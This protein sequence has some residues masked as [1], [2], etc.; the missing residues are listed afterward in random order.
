[1][2][3]IKRCKKRLRH[4]PMDAAE[5]LALLKEN[6]QAVDKMLIAFSGG[7]DSTFLLAVA[8]EVL[9]DEVTAVTVRSA[10][11]PQREYQS[12]VDF[13]RQLGIRHLFL[14]IEELAIPGFAENPPNRC[15]LCK[16]EIFST[17]SA[18]AQSRGIAFVADGSNFDDLLDY[19]PG[20]QALLELGIVSPLRDAGMIKDEIRQLSREMRLPTWDKPAFA[21]LS[22]RFPYGERIT[23]EKLAMVEAAEDYLV[24][25][26]FNQLRVRIH[27]P[28]A[29]IEVSPVE[30]RRFFSEEMMDQVADRL[31]EIGFAYI[32]L[33]LQ[34]YR[35]GS[36]NESIHQ[37]KNHY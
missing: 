29:R 12:A 10:S 13:T 17:I 3:W 22:S 9:G 31:K 1:M 32:S 7:V 34:G 23:R 6:L 37:E 4:K 30:R 11:F 24:S 2:T 18:L 14:T 35:M 36:L 28:I 5:K 27:G 26:G 21:C 33:D 19:R 25:I 16:K 15:Y 8:K 20:H